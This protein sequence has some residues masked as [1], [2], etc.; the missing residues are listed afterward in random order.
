[1]KSLNRIQSRVCDCALYSSEVRRRSP[2]LAGWLAGWLA[3]RAAAAARLLHSLCAKL[4]CLL[5]AEHAGVCAHRR[6]QDQ[7][8][9]ADHA[10]R[11]RAAQVGGGGGRW[12]VAWRVRWQAGWRCTVLC[13]VR[14]GC[15]G[16][17]IPLLT[18]A[19]RFCAAAV[20]RCRTQP[21]RRLWT[22]TSPRQCCW[23]R[24]PSRT[25]QLAAASCLCRV[26]QLSTPRRPLPCEPQAEGQAAVAL[27]FSSRPAR[28]AQQLLPTLPNDSA[29]KPVL[30]RRCCPAPP[31]AAGML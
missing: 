6:G 22:S 13:A 11:D 31:S 12:T 14:R 19:L 16:S 15:R 18:N 27:W 17:L 29:A 5:L 25:C 7:R 23:P 21:L 10:A 26:T 8:R 2:C 30:P 3:L 4:R 9:H 24:Q 20:P 28:T 1:M